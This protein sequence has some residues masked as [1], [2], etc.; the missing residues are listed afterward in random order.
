MAHEQ[1]VTTDPIYEQIGSV[2]RTRRK[3]LGMTQKDLAD[4][5][6]IS[7]GSLANIETGRQNMLVH[8]LYRFAAVL[9]L[10]RTILLPEP[11]SQAAEKKSAWKELP[12]PAG[13]KALHRDQLA[14]LI[15]ETEIE[16]PKLKEVAR[17]KSAKNRTT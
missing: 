12:L 11:T 13:L 8:Q 17:G 9:K 14:R 10:D 6:A 15:E 5:L 16:S 3:A 4:T 7:R 1:S 2:I